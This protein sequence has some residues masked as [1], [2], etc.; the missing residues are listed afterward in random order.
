MTFAG[1]ATAAI[2]RRAAATAPDA[3]AM[4]EPQVVSFN[5][6]MHSAF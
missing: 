4:P 6:Q 1:T 5:V 2:G 3:L